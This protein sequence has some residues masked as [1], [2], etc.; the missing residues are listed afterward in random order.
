MKKILVIIFTILFILPVVFSE[1]APY[2]S[3][4]LSEG[5][6]M[7]DSMSNLTSYNVFADVGYIITRPDG[8][9]YMMMYELIYQGPGLRPLGSSHL[10]NGTRII[11][12]CLSI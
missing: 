10:P 8:S 3:F 2:I 9:S 11:I 1:Q 5:I 7:S 12:S 6:V 4:D